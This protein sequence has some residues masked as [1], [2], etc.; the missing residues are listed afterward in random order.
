MGAEA[1]KSGIADQEKSYECSKDYLWDDH[2]LRGVT[3]SAMAGV[4]DAKDLPGRPPYGNACRGPAITGIAGV[5]IKQSTAKQMART[6]W[7]T[8]VKLKEGALYNELGCIIENGRALPL[9]EESW[10]LAVQRSRL[11]LLNGGRRRVVT[12]LH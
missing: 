12:L 11:S 1:T 7:R 8:K 10:H 6:H 9:R 3:L 5:A 2:G 4:A